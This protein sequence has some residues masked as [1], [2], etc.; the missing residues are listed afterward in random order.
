MVEYS[1][2]IP[3]QEECSEDD[4]LILTFGTTEEPFIFDLNVSIPSSKV[5]PVPLSLK[6]FA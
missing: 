1:K 4:D 6:L 2:E 3:I 5:L